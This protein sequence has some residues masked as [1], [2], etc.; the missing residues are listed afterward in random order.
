MYFVQA[1]AEVMGIRPPLAA[2]Q[3]VLVVV[4]QV[5]IMI[6]LT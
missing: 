1:V 4:V 2:A 6:V 5:V 3:V